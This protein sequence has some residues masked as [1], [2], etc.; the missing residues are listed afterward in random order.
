M[1]KTKAFTV[2]MGMAVMAA[3]IQGSAFAQDG[4][5]L[6]K[7]KTCIACHGADGKKPIMPTYPKLAGQSE[8]YALQ[9][10]KDI[11]SGAR[12]NGQSGAMKTVMQTVSESE[13]AAIA[14]WLSGLK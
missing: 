6:Y 12:D 9:Q 11:K 2:L 1:A 3:G 13:M 14:K 10:M 4:E 5:A 8:Q 7:S